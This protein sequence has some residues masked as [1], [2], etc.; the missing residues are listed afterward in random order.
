MGKTNTL[1]L[2]AAAM[3]AAQAAA[4]E[5]KIDGLEWQ[6][7]QRL[8]LGKEPAR[9]AFSSFPDEKSAL[10]ILPEFAP[11]QLS[12]D[13]EK[14][15]KFHWSKDPSVR[16]AKFYEEDF[17][18]SGWDTIKVPCSW[19]AWGANDKGGWGTAIYTNQA[20]PFR[21]DTPGSSRVTL[22]PPADWTAH[23]ARN[24]VGSYRRDFNVPGSWQGSDVFLKFDGVDSFYYLWVNGKYVGFMKDS[25]SPAEFNV[26]KFVR[27]GEKNTV[28]LEVYRYSDGSYLEDQDMFRLSGIFRRTWL[29]A[30]PKNRV[31]DF[32]A[33][34]R[35]VLEGKYDGAWEVKVE[36][37]GGT[38][39]ALFTWEGE[40]VA[41]SATGVFTVV[42]PKLWSAE[43]PNCYKLVVNNGEEWVSSVFGFRVSEIRNGRYYFNGKPIKLKGANRHESDPY[44]GHYVPMWRH[45]QDAKMMKEANCNTVRNSHYPQ[46][47]Y[48]YY[49]C[50]T[51]GLYEVDEANV[52]SHGYG[53]GVESLSHCVQWRKATVDRNMAMVERNK[54]HPS[55]V[56][57][58]YGNE[59][60]PGENFAAARDAIKSRDTTRPTHYERDWEV[61]DMDGCQYPSVQWVW[62]KAREKESV[63]P[64]YISEYAH[65]MGNAMG[66]LKDY[67][68]AIESS[69]VILGATI[70]DWVDQ[71][72]WKKDAEGRMILAYGGD[73]GD[74][75]ND[76]FF[77][78][79][80]TVL[81]DRTPKPAYEEVF[82]VYQNWSV[83]ATN[84]FQ[85]VVVR[86]KNFFASANDV[87]LKWEALVDG[88]VED[89]GMFDLRSLGP[90]Q[91][92]VYD[93]PESA[94]NLVRFGGSVSLR[95][96]FTKFGRVI[97]TE[98][99]EMMEGRNFRAFSPGKGNVEY[100]E[101]KDSLVFKAGGMQIAFSK[102]TLLPCSVKKLGLLFDKEL[103]KDPFRLDVYRARI[104]NEE[105]LAKDSRHLGFD[106]LVPVSAEYS[107][108]EE[109][110][111]ALAFTSL[112]TWE[113]ND[114]AFHIA[115]RWTI[116]ANG[117]VACR[118]KVRPV[119]PRRALQRIGYSFTLDDKNPNVEWF[120]LGPWENYPDRKSGAFLG[121][122]QLDAQDFYFPYG[123]GEDCGNREG[124]RGVKIGDL[125]LRT[126]GEP[127][128]FSVCPWTSRELEAAN[129][130]QELEKSDKTVA[131]IYA[132]VRGLGG[133]S[134]GPGPLERD[135]LRTDGDY[136]LAF[137]IALGEK[138][139]AARVPDD[140]GAI[141]ELPER[142]SASGEA[143][144]ACSS[145]EPG[146]GEPEHLLDGDPDTIWH[147]QY[148]TTM[149]SFPHSVAIRFAKEPEVI[150]GLICQGRRVGVNGRIKNCTVETSED[151]EHWTMQAHAILA[152]TPEMQ[153]INFREGV[154]AKFY[155][156]T[157]LDNHYG[158]DFASM[159]ELKVV[160]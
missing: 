79:N 6:D 93:M 154:K 68:D 138:E 32:F 148:G 66:N 34:A 118:S 9:A 136:E 124:T 1:I 142:V 133:A 3:V 30:R 71:G 89:S 53:Y 94:V 62:Q 10:D 76:G 106:A 27:F 150:R 135:I 12:L 64:F 15:W 84:Y 116:Y 45:E 130:P 52:E 59:A 39:C 36:M 117:I 19:Q 38:E 145:R 69:D 110:A 49:L 151:G 57:W 113:A 16:P 105:K 35:P 17:D 87:K 122:W 102:S 29:L 88:K 141:P 83:R 90:Q 82:H 51:I 101:T 42:S 41:R 18:V 55:I 152:N 97:A 81:S 80:G 26:T 91:E 77:V 132:R 44:F 25:R 20:Y 2:V 119:G 156:F 8:S 85:R 60:G 157:A 114:T 70:W 46:D 111:G 139:L 140:D 153:Q 56:I 109:K 5:M 128:S 158:N 14:A 72:L 134:C 125:T 131:G 58:S 67:Q 22:A 129:H 24:P 65:N 127:F 115:A 98:Q 61:A 75:P 31:R 7:N 144:I 159:A 146:E 86:N 73:F 11:R 160:K 37:D 43:E 149:G 120:G 123:R 50:D 143:V 99:I 13:S 78:M 4:T 21:K 147:S 155:R 137:T 28:A 74:K 47:D 48:W 63:K 104:S 126:L 96:T 112:S 108:I 100:S 40:E 107:T 95:F 92:A 103:L 121:R 23:D 33:T 54:N